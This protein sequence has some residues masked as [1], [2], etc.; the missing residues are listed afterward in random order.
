M[1]GRSPPTTPG[2]FAAGPEK[3]PF[4]GHFLTL[5]RAE[6]DPVSGP[7]LGAE[8]A[9][10][11]GARKAYPTGDPAPGDPGAGGIWPPTDRVWPRSARQGPR[12]SRGVWQSRPREG[13]A[14]PLGGQD[15]GYPARRV[16]IGFPGSE[17]PLRGR[18]S[19]PK[20]DA[21]LTNFVKVQG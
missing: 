9:P 17:R 10:E 13:D 11:A 4:F 14:A 5:F 6:D 19:D 8:E 21:I 15:Q 2:L 20:Q 7:A 3:M 12:A 16:V 1:S 18:K